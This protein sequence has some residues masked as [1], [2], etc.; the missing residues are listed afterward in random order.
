MSVPERL[1]T[2]RRRIGLTQQ[3]LGEAGGVTKKTQLGY[4]KGL[5]SPPLD[6]FFRIEKTGVNL[7]Y[8][9]FG[10]THEPSAAT[11]PRTSRDI[12]SDAVGQSA[13][14]R[15]DQPSVGYATEPVRQA[16]AASA[17][18]ASYG[19]GRQ[20]SAQQ[21]S[22]TERHMTEIRNR[23]VHGVR[24]GSYDE[25]LQAQALQGALLDVITNAQRYGHKLSTQQFIGVVM[26]MYQHFYATLLSE[27]DALLPISSEEGH[28]PTGT[29]G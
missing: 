9:I 18:T 29:S 24:D 5:A 1:A 6:Y 4:E 15:A 23:I 2:E 16:A 8:V 3:Q 13:A 28:S 21:L 20:V 22:Q 25:S 12:D 7:R 14:H 11:A 10:E 19:P 17:A 27:S 26:E